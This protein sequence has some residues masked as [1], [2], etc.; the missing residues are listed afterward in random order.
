M[1]EV[2]VSRP[3]GEREAIL[4]WAGSRVGSFVD[5]GCFDPFRFS[6]TGFLAD[7]GWGGICVDAAP[8]AAAACAIRY[9]DR[10]DITVMLG[11]FAVDEPATVTIHW[12]PGFMY[13]SREANLRSDITLAPLEMA[14][15]K[16]VALAGRVDELAP[17]LFCSIDLE[18]SSLDALRWL[19]DVASPDCVCVEANN[20]A[21]RATV[22]GWLAGWDEAPVND[23]NLVL[24]RR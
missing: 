7:R 15:L 9:A 2:V 18:G 24:A 23:H 14:P 21:D 20:P 4:C 13:S 17:P 11:A 16:L 22:R 5:F 10:D 6:N 3:Q 12:S 19:L 8:D 1:S